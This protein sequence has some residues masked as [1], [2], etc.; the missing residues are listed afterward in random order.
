MFEYGNCNWFLIFTVVNCA[1]LDVFAELTC[2]YSFQPPIYYVTMA[3]FGK[4]GGP[5]QALIFRLSI[6]VVEWAFYP[7]NILLISDTCGNFYSVVFLIAFN[8]DN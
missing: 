1:H 7:T 5:G 2:Q 6:T 8:D 4:V 3:I